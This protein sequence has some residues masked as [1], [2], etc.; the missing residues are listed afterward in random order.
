M[1]K[2]PII[3]AAAA[4]ILSMVVARLFSI[5][6]TITITHTYTDYQITPMGI[7]LEV[8]IISFLVFF[9]LLWS[10]KGDKNGNMGSRE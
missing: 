3:I 6:R 10:K 4:Y 8:V 1:K 2:L 9:I 7:L 5:K